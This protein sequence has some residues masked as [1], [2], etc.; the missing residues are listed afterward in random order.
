[1]KQTF[2]AFSAVLFCAWGTATVQ[3]QTRPNAPATAFSN[4]ATA[5]KTTATGSRL[6]AVTNRT[7]N[8]G[9][10]VISDSSHSYYSPG[11]GYDTKIEDWKYDHATSWDY[12]GSTVTESYHVLHTFDAGNRVTQTQYEAFDG[13]NWVDEEFYNYYYDANGNV[14]TELDAFNN[15]SSWDSSRYIYNYNAAG[16]VT[17][18]LI[19][20]WD[21]QTSQWEGGLRVTNT[22][23]A[24]GDLTVSLNENWYN[25]QWM[26][27]YRQTY[28][29]SGNL[30]IERVTETYNMQW[31]N[32]AKTEYA[33]GSNNYVLVEENFTWMNNAWE[34]SQRYTYTYSTQGDKLTSAMDIFS[35]GG[36]EQQNLLT[37]TYN[38]YHQELSEAEEKWDVIQNKYILG[39]YR[40]DFYYEEYTNGVKDARATG[41]NLTVFPVPAHDILHIST[42]LPAPAAASLQL[43]DMNGRIVKEAQLPTTVQQ[44]ITIS[45]ASLPAGTYMLQMN[46]GGKLVTRKVVVE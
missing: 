5:A 24:A 27:G 32:A 3:A 42:L 34:P 12:S 44:H 1:M 38:S 8:A 40:I 41:E 11:M 4:P 29:Y 10:F 28:T 18:Q 46:A 14:S 26:P 30:L 16:Q 33:Y 39:G 36:Y 21:K 7:N 2:L 25:N 15:G 45:T 23:N 13:S 35:S 20:H 22:Y 17:Q 19:E 9:S 43:L 37:F 6:I 31:E